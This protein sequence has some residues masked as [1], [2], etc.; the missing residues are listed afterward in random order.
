MCSPFQDAYL[1][2]VLEVRDNSAVTDPA[3]LSCPYLDASTYVS[4]CYTIIQSCLSKH[5]Y[6]FWPTN[7]IVS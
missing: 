5:W 4:S 3:K 6:I 2:A 1:I 7:S